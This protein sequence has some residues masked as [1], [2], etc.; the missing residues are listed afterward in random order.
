MRTFLQTTA[1]LMCS[2]SL[3]LAQQRAVQGV[4]TDSKGE[5]LPG[6]TVLVKGT[7]VGATTGGDG[8]FQIALPAGATTLTISFVGSK[9]QEVVVGN[10]TNL[11][12]TLESDTQSLNDVVVVGYG[13]ARK[14][15][16]T[17][18]VASV[19]NAQLTQVATADPVQALQGRVAGVDITANSGQPGAGTRIRVR[20]VG[21]I[22]NS[23]P[24]YVVDGVQTGDI[25]FL[26]PT[27]IESTE[28]L[29]DA[30][31]TAIYGSRGANGVVII[32]TKHGKAGKTQFNLFGY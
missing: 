11:R 2:T 8:S 22:N 19:S 12:I 24:L 21:T 3:A 29:K 31:A 18:A 14:S 10:Q 13:T 7:T 27:D 26:L 9:S 17:G 20:G 28:I 30:S 32:T 6:A 25:S 23:D 5:G 4:V 16:L 1:V 15:D